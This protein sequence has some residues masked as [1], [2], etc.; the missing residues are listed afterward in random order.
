MRAMASSLSGLPAHNVGLGWGGTLSGPAGTA[1][2][3]SDDAAGPRAANLG[4]G[5][6]LS[7]EGSKPTAFP[8]DTFQTLLVLAKEMQSKED[9]EALQAHSVEIHEFLKA[10]SL[11]RVKTVTRL[12]LPR[13]VQIL[14]QTVE[15]LSR[16]VE[17]LLRHYLG[18]LF[19]TSAIDGGWP[20]FGNGLP[21]S[22]QTS[23][24]PFP[25]K[26]PEKHSQPSGHTFKFCQPPEFPY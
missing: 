6:E 15:V 26:L 12:T 11:D 7:H 10:N 13:V 9:T 23:G 3:N 17:A 21:G 1:E 25:D 18:M 2:V 19:D 5:A 20:M 22:A 16:P 4:E 8:D 24:H 14:D